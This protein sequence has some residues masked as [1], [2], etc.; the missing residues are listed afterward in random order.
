MTSPPVGTCFGFEIRSPLSFD[1][2]RE[3]S[4]EALEVEQAA[5]DGSPADAALLFDWPAIGDQPHTR[6]LQSNG[7]Y[8]YWVDGGGCFV[9]EPAIPRVTVPLGVDPIRR[10]ER[11]WSLPLLLCFASRGDVALHAAA[12]EVDGWA[13]LI[14]APRTFGKTTLAAGFLAAGH[15]VLTEDIACVRLGPEPHVIPGPAMLRIRHD[16]AADLELGA[17]QPVRR[18]RTR[19]H[20]ALAPRDRGTS[21]PV[22]LRAIVLLRQHDERPTLVRVNAAEALPDLWEL[23]FRFRG[24]PAFAASFEALADLAR[25]V[26][27]WNLFRPLRLD[28]LDEAVEAVVTGV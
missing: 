6:L 18:D 23:N 3:G 20:L 1:F 14:A 9:I 17:A 16:V 10:E 27:V 13:V 11:L 5:T 28:M 15:R 7:S 12:V 4:G 19:L 8:R 26:S 21:D 2:L 24:A 25:S 22:P